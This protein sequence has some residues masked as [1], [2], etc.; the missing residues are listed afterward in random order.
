MLLINISPAAK[1][2][3]SEIAVFT[4]EK[5][6]ISQ[7]NKYI[8]DIFDAFEELSKHPNLGKKADSIYKSYRIYKIN[9]HCIFYTFN[10][11]NLI[12][13]GIFHEKME[14]SNYI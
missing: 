6:G 2:D 1:N 4:L 14:P 3:L 11:T 13:A 8:K 7:R 9:K 10:S 5:W 12:I